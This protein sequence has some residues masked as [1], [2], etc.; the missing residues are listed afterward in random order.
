MGFA[1]AAIVGGSVLSGLLGAKGAKDQASAV[2]D[3]AAESA[4]VQK[5]M[6]DISRQDTA[7]WR[8]AGIGALTPLMQGMGFRVTNPRQAEQQRRAQAAANQPAVTGT[9]S[10]AL[11]FHIQTALDRSADPAREFGFHDAGGIPEAA[12]PALAKRLGI[13]DS[14][15]GPAPQQSGASL[16]DFARTGFEYVGGGEFQTPLT[17]DPGAEFTTPQ[18]FEPGAEFTDEFVYDAEDLER[19]PGYQF[20]MDEGLKGLERANAAAGLSA[21]GRGLKGVARWAQ[22]YASNEYQ[23]GYTR[24]LSDLVRRY[25]VEQDVYNTGIADL[26]RRYGV[27]LDKFNSRVSD[28]DRRFN[29]LASI[30]GFGQTASQQSASQAGA[31]GARLG[32]LAQGTGQQLANI[33]GSSAV[34]MNN[35]IQGGIGNYMGYQ[36]QQQ[37]APLM[38]AMTKFYGGG[39]AGAGGMPSGQPAITGAAP[40][41]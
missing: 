39:A 14:V 26:G 3:A 37:M 35:A 17:F 34:A 1:T 13:P 28:V 10:D 8:Q 11:R 19:D 33:H 20:R 9:D 32:A 23:R 21:S 29:R 15:A 7:P 2:R 18:R 30:S 5:E 25:G 31:T 27:A 16:D 6:F 12:L 24:S 4:R 22:D 38:Q 36:Q 40:V 41:Y